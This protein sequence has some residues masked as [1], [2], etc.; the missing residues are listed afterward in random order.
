[1]TVNEKLKQIIEAIP[2]I[3]Y[4]AYNSINHVEKVME[5]PA[6]LRLPRHSDT[7]GAGNKYTNNISTNETFIILQ[8]VRKKEDDKEGLIEEQIENEMLSIFLK[9]KAAFERERLGDVNNTIR[10]Y[11][12]TT[13][14]YCL[15]LEFTCLFKDIIEECDGNIRLA[16]RYSD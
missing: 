15:V 10:W 3:K 1:M 16:K 9:L 2:E 12:R 4:Y 8:T 5:Y 6:L 13:A 7:I 11:R 14:D